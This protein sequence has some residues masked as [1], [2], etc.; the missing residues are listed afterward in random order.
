MKNK[1]LWIVFSV[2][3]VLY[4][5]SQLLGG[6]RAERSFNPVLFSLDTAA[7]TR[8]DLYTRADSFE[9]VRIEK[10]GAGWMASMGSIRTPAEHDRVMALLEQLLEAKAQRIAAK[11]ADRWP[12]FELDEASAK[13]HV[14]VMAGDQTVVDLWVGGFRFNQQTRAGTSFLRKGE[15][16][17]VYALDGFISMGLAQGIDSYRNKTLLRLNPEELTQVELQLGAQSFNY[18]KTGGQWTTQDGAPLDSTKMAQYLGGLANFNGNQ[19]AD[20]FAED[21]ANVQSRQRLVLRGNNMAAALEVDCFALS[22]AAQPFVVRSSLNP[23]YF[24]GDSTGL[25]QRLFKTPLNLQ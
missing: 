25:Y 6:Q 18:Q 21:Q 9:R 10:E 5:L 4:L 7:V 22:G 13:A 3:L 17:D 8:S 11:K 14:V 1:T 24:S 2:L 15:A 16:D 23:A 20:G 12:N 19:F